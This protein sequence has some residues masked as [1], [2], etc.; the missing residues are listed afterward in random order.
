MS[1]VLSGLT[2]L[3]FLLLAATSLGGAEAG[4]TGPRGVWLGQDGHDYCQTSSALGP[5]DIQD[6]HLQLENLPADLEIASLVVRRHG[7]GE[8]I[9]NGKSRSWRGHLIRLPHAPTANLYLEPSH[10]E[11]SFRLDCELQFSSGEVSRFSVQGGRSDPNLFMPAA[12]LKATWIGQDGQDWTGPGPA[13]GPDGFEDARL[14]LTG[15]STRLEVESISIEP[16]TGPAWEYGLNPKRL[17]NAELIR[18]KQDRSRGS[19]F[20]SPD[21]NLEGARLNVRIR[22]KIDRACST[23]VVAGTTDPKRSVPRP[24]EFRVALLPLKVEWLGQ[25]GQEVSGPGD[26]HIIIEG[27]PACASS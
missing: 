5:N 4:K 13:V 3:S 27:L 12:Q 9:V 10:D 2:G 7:G 25:G 11:A 24:P 17:G 18:D 16:P 20:F 23:T 15:L 21:R 8:W 22:Y 6:L 26:V 1:N 14:E 19:L